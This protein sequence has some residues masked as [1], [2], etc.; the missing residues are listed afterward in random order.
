MVN[1]NFKNLAMV[2]DKCHLWKQ[3]KPH[4]ELVTIKEFS[5]DDFSSMADESARSLKKCRHCGQL[6]FYEMAE[7]RDMQGGNDPIYRTYIPVAS[8]EVADALVG[9]S[10]YELTLH[11]PHISFSWPSSGSQSIGW[12]RE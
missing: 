7:L 8:S 4:P 6:Y 11:V 12:V 1:K 9:V 10:E 3:E 5:P 2:P